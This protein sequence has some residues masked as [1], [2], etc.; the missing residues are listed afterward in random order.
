MNTSKIVIPKI[1]FVDGMIS[2]LICK[3]H[4]SEI[5]MKSVYHT[6]KFT[7]TWSTWPKGAPT[8]LFL[9][10]LELQCKHNVSNPMNVSRVYLRKL[11][12]RTART[13]ILSLSRNTQFLSPTRTILLMD[14]LLS[15]MNPSRLRVSDDYTQTFWP[16]F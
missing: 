4:S 7:R 3:F 8:K 1:L 13:E 10:S 2:Y 9:Y 16:T 11:A 14:P 15:Q 5:C 12:S 6:S